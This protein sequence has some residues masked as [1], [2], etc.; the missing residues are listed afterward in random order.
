LCVAWLVVAAPA[1]AQASRPAKDDAGSAETATE[2][3]RGILSGPTIGDEPRRARDRFG[4]DSPRQDRPRVRP[5][6]W[7]RVIRELDLTPDEQQEIQPLVR[8]FQQAALAFQ[9]EHGDEM[10]RIQQE[11]RA[12]QQDDGNA[13]TIAALR[14][15]GRE[16]NEKAPKIEPVQQEIWS[17][18][19]EDQQARARAGLRELAPREGRRRNADGATDETMAQ[20]PAS[21][22]PEPADMDEM[23]RRRLRF[24]E[25]RRSRHVPTGDP[26][27]RRRFEFDDD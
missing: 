15:R 2:Q 14:A 10:R 25:A 17:L 3:D 21:R 24:L 20:G 11:L 6:Q 16:L 12:L 26:G 23:A 1:R 19:D 18:L 13:E 4:S 22:P 8:A 7:F 5:R 9:A 27:P